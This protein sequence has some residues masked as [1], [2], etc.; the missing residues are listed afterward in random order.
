MK[1]VYIA[2]FLMAFILTT[3]A[4]IFLNGKYENMFAFDFSPRKVV[5]EQVVYPEGDPRNKQNDST[6]A[7][8]TQLKGDSLS[9]SGHEVKPKI[10]QVAL[11]KRQVD[12][13]KAENE[14][15]KK[16]RME[17]AVKDEELKKAREVRK[18][19]DDSSY[20][21]WKK[22]MVKTFEQMDA[23]MAAKIILKLN[24]NQAKDIL[25]TMKKK[26]A[27]QIIA[28]LKP[29]VAGRLIRIQ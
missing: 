28:E 20:T 24:D 22:E 19:R 26:K 29:D 12:S 13:L 9:A 3:G 18:V 1:I 23:K 14:K 8:N 21:K 16:L 25:F 15:L 6:A 2:V 11:I 10:D 4:M 7:H 17:V 5:Q 27:A